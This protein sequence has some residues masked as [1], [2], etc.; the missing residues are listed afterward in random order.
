M[1]KNKCM[2]LVTQD[3]VTATVMTVT[4]SLSKDLLELNTRNRKFSTYTEKIYAL[5]MKEGTWVLNGETIKIDWEGN[6]L[7]GQH[8]LTACLETG[9]PFE[10]ILVTGLD[11]SVFK[12]IDRGKKRSP[13]DN[14]SLLGEE[15][16]TVLGAALS[17]QWKYDQGRFFIRGTGA[18]PEINHLL[19]TLD[20]NP[21]IRDAVVR[22]KKLH[23][24]APPSLL[25]FL[26]YQFRQRDDEL[27]K[28][29]LSGLGEGLG[30]EAGSPVY[31]L[32]ERLLKNRLE[33]KAKLPLREIAALI[34][35]A[36]NFMVMGRTVTRLTWQSG[37]REG[38]PEILPKLET[39]GT[40]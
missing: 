30:L 28:T 10:T 6:L 25:T 24:L 39:G 14:L 22:S 34:I 27:S 31:L 7:D 33:A 2:E 8:R 23:I 9:V 19:D 12:S 5:Q 35:K 3:G 16:A 20:T 1:K 11:P 4:P 37:R 13:S 38:F 26:N 21:G 17:H 40:S 15:D 18:N 32:R 29:F 36:W